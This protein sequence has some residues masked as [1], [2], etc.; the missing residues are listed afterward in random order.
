M[1]RVLGSALYDSDSKV[2]V[3]RPIMYFL[4]NASRPK[5]LEVATSNF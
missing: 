1:L 2:K 5:S 3:K 4:V